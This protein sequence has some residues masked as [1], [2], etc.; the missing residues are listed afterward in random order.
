MKMKSLNVVPDNWL[1]RA[2]GFK[3]T[4]SLVGSRLSEL[5]KNQEFKNSEYVE[6]MQAHPFLFVFSIECYLKYFLIK[7]GYRPEDLE[8]TR[9]FGHDL[10]KL[11]KECLKFEKKFNDFETFDYLGGSTKNFNGIKYPEGGANWSPSDLDLL[12]RLDKLVTS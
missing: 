8:K 10:S 11:R 3:S 12:M 7:K 5:Y 9:E 1:D 4:L 2:R 6:L